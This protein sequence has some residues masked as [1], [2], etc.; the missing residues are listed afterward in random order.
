MFSDGDLTLRTLKL[1]S[2]LEIS[3]VL[4]EFA[5]DCHE[6]DMSLKHKKATL[7]DVWCTHPYGHEDFER[8]CVGSPCGS[9]IKKVE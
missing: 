3:G 7:S 9:S 6:Y 5:D 8:G 4:L 2:T 1:W